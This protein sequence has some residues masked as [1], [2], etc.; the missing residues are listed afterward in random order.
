M[1]RSITS[2]KAA[3][4]TNPVPNAAVHRGLL[5]TSGILG[6]ELETRT[7]PADKA[8]Q[9]DL[10]FQYLQAILEEAGAGLQD[11][12]KL[13]LYFADKSDRPLANSHWVR[14]WPNP[15]SRPARQAHQTVMPEG[16]VIQL[17][18]MAVLPPATD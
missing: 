18:A 8:R 10:V 16:C 15:G 12:I 1:V 13:D 4:H 14:L 6:K 9:F 11:V 2:P 17:V 5:V 3:Q 7:Y